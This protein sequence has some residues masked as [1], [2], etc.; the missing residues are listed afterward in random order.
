[1]PTKRSR[2]IAHAEELAH[3]HKN[4]RRDVVEVRAP[5]PACRWP[6][7]LDYRDSEPLPGVDVR[8]ESDIERAIH[9]LL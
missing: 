4:A 7:Q 2:G 1:M 8:S 9:Q 5:V 3:A 6:L